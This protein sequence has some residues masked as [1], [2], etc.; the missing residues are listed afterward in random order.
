[1]LN[2]EQIINMCLRLKEF[3]N[4]YRMSE[5]FIPTCTM[6]SEM[7]NLHHIQVPLVCCTTLSG[8]LNCPYENTVLIACI[9]QIRVLW[10][11]FPAFAAAAPVLQLTK[12]PSTV[13]RSLKVMNYTESFGVFN[14]GRRSVLAVRVR[15]AGCSLRRDTNTCTSRIWSHLFANGPHESANEV[16]NA[17]CS[18]HLTCF[19][20]MQ[21]IRSII[22]LIIDIKPH[23]KS[24]HVV[25]I[26]HSKCL[27]NFTLEYYHHIISNYVDFRTSMSH[28]AWT[29]CTT[30][31]RPD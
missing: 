19:D 8:S 16:T 1:M 18:S 28:R 15:T 12:A 17:G 14:N 20:K 5:W 7:F 9:H 13:R 27:H 21:D 10:C 11:S 3:W 25:F 29:H 26:V 22:F 24:G 4:L 2:S 6:I 31:L 23:L 30:L